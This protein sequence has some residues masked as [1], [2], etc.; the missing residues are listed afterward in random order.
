MTHTVRAG[1]AILKE[2]GVEHGF[3]CTE[4]ASSEVASSTAA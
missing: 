3:V 2:D 1:D 4:A